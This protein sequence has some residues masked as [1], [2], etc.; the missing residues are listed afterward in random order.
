M[1]ATLRLAVPLFAAL[2]IAACNGGAGN[3]PT[4]GVS[5]VGSAPQSKIGQDYRQMCPDMGPHFGQCMV[6]W[7]KNAISPAVNGWAPLDFQT[8]YKLP[9]SKGTGQVVAIV[10]AFD[11]P[12]VA[13]DLAVYRSN[14]GLGTANFFKYNQ[15]GQQSN[16]PP[17]N[18]GWGVEIDLDVQM[19]SAVCPKCT[20]Y[21][22]EATS[23]S[24]SD[25]ETAERE[26]VT[27][28]AHVVSNSWGCPGS[29]DCDDPSA[30]SAPHTVYLASAG[31][32]GYGTQA[33]AA[34]ANVVSVGGTQFLKPSGVITET[35][36]HSSGSGCA[37]GITKPSWQHD[38][39]C[40]SR[41]MNDVSAIAQSVAIYDTYGNSGWGEVAGTSVSSPMVGG[42]F[43]LAGNANTLTAG[44]KFWT[45]SKKKRKRSLWDITTGN[46]GS[47]G[48]SYLCTAMKGYDG[49]TGWGSPKGIG[50]F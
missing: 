46:D 22:I 27:L 47:C 23:N 33:P 42:I 28:G 37:T 34:L 18:T 26:A 7:Q 21:L 31:D 17:G 16:Y 10:D 1:K 43:G 25:L 2:A 38:S 29:N 49:P 5:P 35:T 12:N 39:G 45:L 14:F 3:M 24:T 15:T 41:T 6:L 50:A 4:A 9:I 40:S 48:G 20:I 44:K 32:G 13:S 30:F 8:R 19:V 11:N 36:W